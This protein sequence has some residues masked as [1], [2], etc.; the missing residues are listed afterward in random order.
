M[1][2]AELTFDALLVPTLRGVCR[3]CKCAFGV[4]SAPTWNTHK[5]VCWSTLE[6]DSWCSPRAHFG[7]R[8]S[9]KQVDAFDVFVHFGSRLMVLSSR[10]FWSAFVDKGSRR[11]GRFYQIWKSTH[12]ALLAPIVEGVRRHCKPTR[13]TC[14]STL[15]VDFDVVCAPTLERAC[16]LWE[17]T[18]GA[19]LAPTLERVRG[20]FFKF[21]SPF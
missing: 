7:A 13:S 21:S 11:V 9:T 12:G 4:L 18:F 17:L 19:L 15:G 10:P 14:V 2:V 16:R 5:E 1:R 20:V 3:L 6:V 8:S